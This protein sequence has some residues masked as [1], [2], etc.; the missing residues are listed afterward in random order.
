MLLSSCANRHEVVRG[1]YDNNSQDSIF[2]SDE[3]VIFRQTKY[4][5]YS[6]PHSSTRD[7]WIEEYL[8][9][10]KA[11]DKC[12]TA[13]P[14]EQRIVKLGGKGKGHASLVRR[15]QISR[16]HQLINSNNGRST[17]KWATYII[18]AK[19]T[20]N[21]AK[22]NKTGKDKLLYLCLSDKNINKLKVSL[23]FVGSKT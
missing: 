22:E 16:K 14:I 6:P 5:I 7:L 18:K 10:K 1:L 15:A 9:R 21:G 11:R 19:K 2:S 23:N 20:E 12:Q 13:V 17:P 3:K 8:E 4:N